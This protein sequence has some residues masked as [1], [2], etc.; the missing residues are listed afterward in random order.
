MLVPKMSTAIG[1]RAT[2]G[3]VR[4]NSIVVWVARRRNRLEPMIRP[5]MIAAT[6][7]MSRPSAQLVMVSATSFQNAASVTYWP[8]RTS[9]SLA[10]GRYRSLTRPRRG[11]ASQIRKNM[12]I[13]PMPRPRAFALGPAAALRCFLMLASHFLMVG[14]V[15]YGAAGYGRKV[16]MSGA[17]LTAPYF[18]AA[19]PS[20]VTASLLNSVG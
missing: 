17:V 14:G 11:A 7:A 13:P 1:M 10:G 3:I 8:S 16:L 19:L 4:R 15:G 12:T 2:E 20:V 9:T 6:V 18:T 5:T